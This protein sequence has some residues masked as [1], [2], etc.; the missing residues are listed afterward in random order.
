MLCPFVVVVVVDWWCYLSIRLVI[1]FVKHISQESL[2]LV[3]DTVMNAFALLLEG[4]SSSH[5]LQIVSRTGLLS[6]NP[7]S[8]A[9]SKSLCESIT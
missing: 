6:S 7:A 2:E 1:V 5:E 8:S 4:I 9:S 3:S